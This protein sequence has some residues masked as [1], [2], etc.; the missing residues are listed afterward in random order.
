[1]HD[2]TESQA[3]VPTAAEIRDVNTLEDKQKHG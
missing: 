1:M 2:S 3:V